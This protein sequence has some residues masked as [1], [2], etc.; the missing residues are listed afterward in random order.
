M[1]KFYLFFFNKRHKYKKY[2]NNITLLFYI[3]KYIY[4]SWNKKKEMKNAFEFSYI[5]TIIFYIGC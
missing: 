3:Y 5:K 4:I 1:D 2:K